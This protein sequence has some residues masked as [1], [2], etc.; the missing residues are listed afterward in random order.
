MCRGCWEEYYDESKIDND[1]MDDAVAAIE[2]VYNFH[3]AGGALHVVIDDW[4]LEDERITFCE[5][6]AKDNTERKDQLAAEL[7]CIELLKEM[8][9]EERASAL[10]LY[11]G[12]WK[13]GD[14]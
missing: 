4:N 3:L 9:V 12:F 11:E 6:Y 7:H 14:K 8:S 1:K 2:E 13:R 10:A 5:K